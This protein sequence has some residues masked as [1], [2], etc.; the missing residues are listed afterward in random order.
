M[1]T[2]SFRDI[3]HAVAFDALVQRVDWLRSK[4]DAL[5][6]MEKVRHEIAVLEALARRIKHRV[7]AL[8]ARN[9]INLLLGS[10]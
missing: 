5:D 7:P 2:K 9:R 6:T 8:R 1:R 4:D 10:V 3:E